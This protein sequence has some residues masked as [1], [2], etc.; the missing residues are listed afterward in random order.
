MKFYAFKQIIHYLQKYKRI[1]NAH[2]VG[3]NIIKI[4]FD[5]KDD[6]YFDLQKGNSAIYRRSDSVRVK[7]YQAP[8]DVLLHKYLARSEILSMQILKEDK[9]LRIEIAQSGTY[10]SSKVFL[11]LEFTG[12]YTNAILLDEEGV[13]LDALRHVDIMNSYREIRPGV[14]LVDLEAPSFKASE[15]EKIEDMQAYLS[16][17]YLER[18]HKQLLNRQKIEASRVDKKIERMKKELEK[19]QDEDKLL[20]QADK[21]FSDGNLAL[22]NMHLI[23]PYA[24][25]VKLYD[26]SGVE[27]DLE[28]PEGARTAAQ[29]GELFFK[30][31]KK[32]KQKAKG[33]YIEREGL[34][35]KVD[36]LERFKGNILLTQTPEELS[37]LLPPQKKKAKKEPPKSYEVFWIEG[38][39]VLLGKNK[40]GN[41][42]LLKLAK[43]G[44]TWMHIQGMPSTHVIIQTNKQNLSEKLL[45]AAAKLCVDFSTTKTGSF[46]VDYTFRREVKVQS[47][48]NVLYNK[49][50][51]LS[52]LKEH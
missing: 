2:R 34:S 1:S 17:I 33:L 39:K 49:Y 18:T 20:A 44:D 6:I 35:D 12:K 3:D 28:L 46:L 27:I 16:Q 9:V 42:E 7:H 37:L 38:Q 30:K 50:K 8:F 41:I 31:G 10:K 36:F 48:A 14:E 47:E 32:A 24:K 4:S 15:G 5:R 43:A 40:K 22:A 51:T 19:L 52:V 26:F 45:Y 11:Q 21:N 13:I 23:K 25:S 29:V